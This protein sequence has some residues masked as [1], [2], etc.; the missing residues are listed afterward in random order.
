MENIGRVRNYS[1]K[2]Q[3]IQS[4]IDIL[5][6]K[7]ISKVEVKSVRWENIWGKRHYMGCLSAFYKLCQG[8]TDGLRFY[9]KGEMI[10][11]SF[12]PKYGFPLQILRQIVSSFEKIAIIMYL[13]P[14]LKNISIFFFSV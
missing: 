6:D 3:L 1:E 7:V 12:W 11:F 14:A 8:R 9:L 2:A 10:Q 5:S 13:F 4:D